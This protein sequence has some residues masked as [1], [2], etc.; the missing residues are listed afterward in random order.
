M[1]GTAIDI[2]ARC[3]VNSITILAPDRIV[4]CGEMLKD[5][6]VRSDLK[7]SFFSYNPM[8]EQKLFIFSDLSDR[9]DYIGPVAF[10]LWKNYFTASKVD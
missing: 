9:E 7:D 1:F 5:K 8:L 10:F 2:F 6:Q 4:L 3:I